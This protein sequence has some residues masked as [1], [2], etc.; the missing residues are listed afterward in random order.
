MIARV[1][2]KT[3]IHGPWPVYKR[4][5]IGL[6][7]CH[8]VSY[9]SLFGGG[10]YVRTMPAQDSLA[11]V[12]VQRPMNDH[13]TMTVELCDANETRHIC[14]YA[15]PELRRRLAALSTGAKVLLRMSRVGVRAN[16]WRAVAIVENGSAELI[17]PQPDARVR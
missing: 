12:V 17:G 6:N 7:I 10:A 14:E 9:I 1:T 8:Y 15:T 13:G 2:G 4:I 11:R 16:V 5:Y 3:P